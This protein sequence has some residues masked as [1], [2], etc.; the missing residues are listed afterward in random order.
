MK[1]VF[2]YPGGK[3]YLASWVIEHFP[4]HECYVE[5][6]GGSASVLV[7]K[8]RSRI[9]VLNDL[10]GDITHFF[11]T[12]RDHGDE[13]REWLWSTPYSRELHEKYANEFYDGYRPDDDIERAGRFF[14]LRLSQFASKYKTKSGFSSSK[15]TDQPGAYVN[16]VNQL[17]EYADRL[18]G[19]SIESKDF[20]A[21]F[22]DYDSEDTLFYCD[23]P[24]V[25]AGDEM[26]SHGGEFK[27]TDFMDCVE[28]A[29]GDVVV[30]YEELPDCTPEWLT[31]VEKRSTYH[32]SA[33][34][35]GDKKEATERLLCNFDPTDMTPFA[36]A[37]QSNLEAFGD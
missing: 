19:V 12:L 17:E 5:V 14:F 37:D 27:H 6:F 29:E 8:P 1:S 36:G 3:T 21:M 23:P 24:Y 15:V 18:R 31:V 10:D 22:E 33:G 2:P 16:S 30:S 28:A 25:G 32:M 4:D 9:E 20:A 13:L 26:Y 11:T 34:G 35:H 7:S